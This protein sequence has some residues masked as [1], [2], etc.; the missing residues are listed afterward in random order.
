MV[1]IVSATAGRNY[2]EFF[3]R[4][5]TGT[6][7]FPLDSVFAYAGYRITRSTRDLGGLGLR[8]LNSTPEGYR[9]RTLGG[10]QSP[11]VLAGI[12]VGD[13]IVSVDGV[14]IHQVPLAGLFGRNWI[15]ARLIEKKAGEQVIL[16]VARG[17]TRREVAL[18]LNSF[19]EG[20]LR[21]ENDPTATPQ[22]L[23]IRKE[24]LRR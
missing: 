15:G 10:P 2:D 22:A 18:K 21:I 8:M 19:K 12:Q 9:V 16:T 7:D 17:S 23:A 24:W 4:Y 1:R 11:S 20:V 3:R 6:D 14:P 13:V 5:V